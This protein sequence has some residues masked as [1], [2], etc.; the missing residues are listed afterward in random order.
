MNQ[1]PAG[2][3]QSA[4][5]IGT[6]PFLIAMRLPGISS[7]SS[8]EVLVVASACR[9]SFAAD[10]SNDAV[11]QIGDELALGLFLRVRGGVD[12]RARRLV[13]GDEALLGHDLRE[14]S[15]TVV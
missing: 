10:P 6:L 5:V 13:A 12:V 3:L 11:D 15:G 4:G 1:R 2:G 8:G 9:T 14:A 7:S